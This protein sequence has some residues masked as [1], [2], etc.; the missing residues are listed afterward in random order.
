MRERIGRRI[1]DNPQLVGFLLAVFALGASNGVFQT[2]YNNYL[3][4]VFNISA[5]ARGALEFPRELPGFLVALLSGALFF[6]L[7]NRIAALAAVLTGLGMIGLGFIDQS[8]ALMLVFTVIWSIGQHVEMPMRSAIAM[9]LG[10]QKQHGRRLGQASAAR[11][12]ASVVG[13]LVVWLAIDYLGNNWLLIFGIGGIAAL[14]G[15]AYYARMKPVEAPTKRAKLVMKRR[16]GLYYLLCTLFGARKQVFITFA[17][18]VLV[19]VYGEQASTFAKLWIASAVLGVWFQQGLGDMID[20]WGERRVLMADGAVL[21]L[22]CL[23]YAFADQIGLPAGWPVRVLYVCYIMDE[24]LFGVENA[25]S[26]YLAKIAEGPEDVSPS[27][28]MGITLNHGVSM[29]VPYFGAR[30]I[31]DVFGW[32]WVFVAAAGIALLTTAAASFVRTPSDGG[33][34]ALLAKLETGAEVTDLHDG[35]EPVDGLSANG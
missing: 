25:R 18:W 23:G 14:I 34:D 13:G 5:T 12:G 29:L 24:L 15:A 19:T 6:M 8:W 30:Y 9:S 7:E 35:E 10:S 22:I 28:S 17:P 26:A 33:D 21:I 27:L 2:T 3:D 1:R 32:Q 4:D 20:R 16:Y 31:W 11:V